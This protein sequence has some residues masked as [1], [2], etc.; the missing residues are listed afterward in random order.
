MGIF[1]SEQSSS[2]VGVMNFGR[3]KFCFHESDWY[4]V[5]PEDEVEVILGG[6]IVLPVK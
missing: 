3:F 6:G 2:S 4:I 1:A 5:L